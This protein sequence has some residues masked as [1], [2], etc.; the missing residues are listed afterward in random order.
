MTR[1]AV[2][3][4]A[5]GPDQPAVAAHHVVQR[6]SACAGRTVERDGPVLY[7][8]CYIGDHGMYTIAQKHRAG[9]VGWT[10]FINDRVGCR[11]RGY[12]VYQRE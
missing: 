4:R 10:F 8:L 1:T 12:L 3:R 9:T 7:A 11:R 2:Y 5:R 6:L